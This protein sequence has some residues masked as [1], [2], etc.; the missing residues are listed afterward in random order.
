M[1][2]FISLILS[3]I[4]TVS[5]L[6]GNLFTGTKKPDFC[7]KEEFD[8][9]TAVNEVRKDSGVQTLEL[10]EELCQIAR[11]RAKE[12]TELKGHTRPDGSRFYTVF[13]ENGY[14]FKSCGENIFITS[15]FDVERGVQGWY[16]SVSHRENMLDSRWI[17][18]G[19]GI[20]SADGRTYCVQLFAC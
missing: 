1:K 19:V 17:K 18:T 9:Y 3:L 10:D 4:M 16:N 20:Y 2:T 6:F 7:S 12:Q 11:I 14:E 5:G 13:K 15:S 8:I